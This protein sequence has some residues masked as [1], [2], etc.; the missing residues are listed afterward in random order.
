MSEKTDL[1]N[2][3]PK[4]ENDFKYIDDDV[5]QIVHGGL[6]GSSFLCKGGK[7][8]I[9]G[10]SQS[11]KYASWLRIKAAELQYFG[12]NPVHERKN[13]FFWR[14]SPHPYFTYLR[15]KTYDEDQRIITMDWLDSFRDLAIAVWFGD[16][17]GMAG[18]NRKNATLKTQHF[19]FHGSEIICQYFNEV[20]FPC[21]INKHK[22]T[23]LI[24]FTV[25]GTKDLFKLIAN[26]M[27]SPKLIEFMPFHGMIP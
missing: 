2:D 21:S 12:T 25:Q 27:P 5:K 9:L 14:S 6:M 1:E 18:R 11:T 10:M 24:L 23:P 17:G 15:T 13:G 19:G 8:D 3:P 26:A 4:I 22:G 16:K 7:D 20:G